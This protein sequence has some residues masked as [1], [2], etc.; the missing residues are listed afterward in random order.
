MPRTIMR[1]SFK[2][3][4]S[5]VKITRPGRPITAETESVSYLPGGK[6][7]ELHYWYADGACTINCYGQL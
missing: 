7:Y 6:A 3:K 1:T 2:V 4:K 5:K